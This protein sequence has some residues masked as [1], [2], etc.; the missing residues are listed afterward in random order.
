MDQAIANLRE[1][2]SVTVFGSYP[3]YLRPLEPV[4]FTYG[5]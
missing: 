1:F 2:A 3:R 4:N 5:N